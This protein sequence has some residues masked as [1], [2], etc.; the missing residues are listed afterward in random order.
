MPGIDDLARLVLRR[1]WEGLQSGR[2]TVSLQDAAPVMRLAWQI[3][4]DE[5]IPARDK[6]LAELAEAQAGVLSVKDAAIRRAG[7]TNGVSC[8][9]RSRRSWRGR[10]RS[11]R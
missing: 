9:A 5:A 6:A 10:G 7:W 4:R 2:P 3:E 8:G 1:R 11:G